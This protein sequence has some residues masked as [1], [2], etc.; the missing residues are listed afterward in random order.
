MIGCILKHKKQK[1]E[2]GIDPNPKIWSK[3]IGSAMLVFGKM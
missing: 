1:F 3:I 2:L